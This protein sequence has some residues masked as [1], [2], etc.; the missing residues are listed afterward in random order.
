LIYEQFQAS[1][2][3][4]LAALLADPSLTRNI[5][6]N[7]ATE[8]RCLV[9]AHRRIDWHNSTWED[10]GYGV[11]ALRA[12]DSRLAPPGRLLGWCGFVPADGDD[13]DPEILYAIDSDFRGQGIASEAARHTIAW[14]F[15][16]TSYGGVTAVISTRLNP[17]S[18]NVVT[19]L[20]FAARGRMDF[21]LFLSN[22]E[23]A[24]EVVD[25]EIW[26]LAQDSTI[27]LDSLVQQVAYRSGQLS[28]VT[29]L[30]SGRIRKLLLESLSRRVPGDAAA[31]QRQRLRQNLEA[32][33]RKGR[34]EAYMDCYH[35]RRERWLE[36]TRG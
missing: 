6:A 36:M 20:G 18:A 19:K 13:P 11:W 14:L 4:S 3:P 22:R 17:G 28:R 15:D 31:R 9:F 1:D 2:A 25:Y 24:D 27:K 30:P 26:R 8:E 23:L 12:R 34:N 32:E 21:E 5:T 33:F 29:S 35:V 16:Q 10:H 7:G